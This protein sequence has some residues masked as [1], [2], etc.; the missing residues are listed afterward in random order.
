MVS[1]TRISFF[2][3]VAIGLG[4]GVGLVRF[5]ARRHRT[6]EPDQSSLRDRYLQA[7]A[8]DI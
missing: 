6:S 2:V 3:V 8:Q 1:G 5:R 7:L 4:V